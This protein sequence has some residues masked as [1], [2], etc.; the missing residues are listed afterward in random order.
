MSARSS[1][2]D[3]Q[4]LEIEDVVRAEAAATE[5]TLAKIVFRQ[6]PVRG[7]VASVQVSRGQAE[8]SESLAK[9]AFAF[10]ISS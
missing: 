9:Y 5:A 7:L 8:L 4:E 2:P 3:L 10:E 6:D 1:S